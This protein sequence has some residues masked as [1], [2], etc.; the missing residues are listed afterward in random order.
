MDNKYSPERLIE[1]IRKVISEKPD[2]CDYDHTLSIDEYRY[3]EKVS[4]VYKIYESLP[5]TLNELSE[6]KLKEIILKISS[7]EYM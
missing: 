1:E 6:E 2:K 4:E 7:L 5:D 3:I